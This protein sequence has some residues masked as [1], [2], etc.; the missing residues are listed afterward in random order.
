MTSASAGRHIRQRILE[1]P[2]AEP[3]PTHPSAPIARRSEQRVEA[4]EGSTIQDVTQYSAET[5]NTTTNNTF[6]GSALHASAV[7]I[8]ERW[9][10]DADEQA[11]NTL[12]GELPA[13]TAG[14]RYSLRV[15][16]QIF[17]LAGPIKL[18]ISC[19]IG[20]S[21]DAVS[22]VALSTAL[23]VPADEPR[24]EHGFEINV[25]QNCPS[26]EIRLYVE[27]Y[28]VED[29]R[30][31]RIVIEPLLA[32]IVGSHNRVRDMILDAARVTIGG[33]APDGIAVL[34]IEMSAP[35]LFRLNGWS[36]RG[37]KLRNSELRVSDLP[38]VNGATDLEVWHEQI[39]NFSAASPVELQ[40]WLQD[41]V[42]RC[43]STLCLVIADHTDRMVPWEL[44]Y[45]GD[46]AMQTPLGTLAGVARWIP[47][48]FFTQ[49][50]SLKPQEEVRVGRAVAMLAGDH[51]QFSAQSQAL[52]RMGA[53]QVESLSD[54]LRSLR[55]IDDRVGLFYLG[56]QDALA[57]E[58]YQRLQRPGSQPLPEP[59]PLGFIGEIG[60]CHLTLEQGAMSGPI[61]DLL[62]KAASCVIGY[63]G[64]SWSDCVD[65]VAASILDRLASGEP[66][67]EALRAER[68]TRYAC[69]SADMEPEA[70]RA[71][72]EQLVAASLFVYFGNPLVRLQMVGG[73]APTAEDNRE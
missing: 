50:F 11:V 43:G 18:Y 4:R 66:P 32:R 51:T 30:R 59:R 26:G 3:T 29:G 34:H 57:S 20:D 70:Y 10:R 65:Q 17:Q 40:R 37:R 63:V 44:F 33:A 27:G 19:Y 8:S 41:T 53:T 46:Q 61:P 60:Q 54:L 39:Y 31:A 69:L 1:V 42:H 49:W 6:I 12:D 28:Y 24:F 56:G 15:A 48:K 38:S 58:L 47:L 22:E 45:V 35:N 68:E 72:L 23:Q 55:R 25:Q 52:K 2:R 62:M 64:T 21:N 5:I 14:Q 7:V 36:Y 67:A 16:G 71:A 13:L 73:S 9:L